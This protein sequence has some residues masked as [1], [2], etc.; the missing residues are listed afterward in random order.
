M[1]TWSSGHTSVVS[2]DHMILLDSVKCGCLIGKR[3]P[4]RLV[5]VL[6][7]PNSAENKSWLWLTSFERQRVKKR[8]RRPTKVN[9]FTFCACWHRPKTFTIFVAKNKHAVSS[10]FFFVSDLQT[11]VIVAIDHDL[12]QLSHHSGPHNRSTPGM[13]MFPHVMP[14]FTTLFG[15]WWA[16]GK[17]LELQ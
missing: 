15:F 17:R 14:S 4:S 6:K 10:V 1:D 3:F 9:N 11:E 12:W 13:C 8:Y 2:K 5:M 16:V 7:S